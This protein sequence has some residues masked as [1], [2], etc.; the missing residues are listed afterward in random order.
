MNISNNAAVFLA[1][2]GEYVAAE[3]IDVASIETLA[4]KKTSVRT[5]MLER[6]IHKDSCLLPVF[7]DMTSS[8]NHG[9]ET[10]RKTKSVA[11]TKKSSAK[12]SPTKKSSAKKSPAKKS[13]GKK[14]SAKKSSGKKSSGKKSSAKKSSGKK[15]PKRRP[16]K[17]CD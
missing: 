17:R 7:E 13:S 1:A 11:P 14:S 2:V 4:H 5:S 12:K 16:K 15:K 8:R 10:P 6:A 3:L 9:L